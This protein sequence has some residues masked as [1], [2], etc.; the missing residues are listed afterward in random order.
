MNKDEYAQMKARQ[1][2]VNAFLGKLDTVNEESLGLIPAI[3]DYIKTGDWNCFEEY[4]KFR[5][6]KDSEEIAKREEEIAKREEWLLKNIEKLKT[7]KKEQIENA[8]KEFQTAI[9]DLSVIQRKFRDYREVFE[10]WKK[11]V[12]EEIEK[13]EQNISP[14]AS[15][16]AC[17]LRVFLND[18]ANDLCNSPYRSLF[19]IDGKSLRK[20]QGIQIIENHGRKNI[21]LS[22]SDVKTLSSERPSSPSY[23]VRQENLAYFYWE[24]MCDEANF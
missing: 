5:A 12:I 13:Q 4:K 19:V 16:T 11:E 24:R 20:V 17:R 23:G 2:V 1:D 14:A 15:A 21:V 7:S 3:V 6:I 18:E 10:I 8:K 9:A 22:M